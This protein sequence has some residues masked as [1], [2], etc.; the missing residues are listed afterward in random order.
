MTK[1]AFILAT[2][3]TALPVLPALGET[4]T[5]TISDTASG[6]FDG[7]AFSDELVTFTQ[8]TDTSDIS[9]T[10]AACSFGYPC[11]PDQADN[12]VTIAGVG[13]ETIT[14][15]TYFF[16]NGINLVGF[17]NEVDAAYLAAE[18]SSLGSYNLTTG[19]GPTAYSIYSG[20]SVSGLVTSG[21]DLTVSSFGAD[22][23]FE[24]VLGSSTSPVPEPGSF[25]LVLA[26]VLPL[27]IGLLRRPKH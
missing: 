2:V 24:A 20:S 15:D 21:G 8:V 18:D 5:F 27:G 25:G 10:T 16:A 17:T 11:A 4:I 7:T 12:T 22:A 3:L 6:S 1:T 14:G 19:F 9:D 13:T 23:T 26:G